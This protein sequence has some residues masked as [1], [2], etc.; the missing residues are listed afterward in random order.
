[1]NILDSSVVIAYIR[2]EKGGDFLKKLF[3]ECQAN[4]ESIFIHEINFMEV[5]YKVKSKLP[6]FPITSLLAEFSSP[7]WGKLS[8]MESDLMLLTADIKS[9][10]PHASL[11]DCIGLAA[12]KIFKGTFWTADKLLADIGKSAGITVQLIR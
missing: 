2:K 8:Y 3:K 10:F 12:T 11:A 9:E 5:I 1:M 4:K 6:S 7:W